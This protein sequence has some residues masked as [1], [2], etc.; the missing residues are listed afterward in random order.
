MIKSLRNFV[1]A[2]IAGGIIFLLPLAL[3]IMV[4]EK[5]YQMLRKILEPL[6]QMLPDKIFGLDGRMILTGLLLWTICFV[7][8]LLFLSPRVKKA[9]GWLEESVLSH[10]P[11]YNLTKSIAAD[12]IG[13]NVEDKM[14]PVLVQDG[15]A[16]KIGYL[17]E[18]G[19][20]Q[21]TVFYPDAP[22][23]DAGEVKIVPAAAVRKVDVPNNKVAQSLR[24]FGKGAIA[25]GGK[26]Q[27]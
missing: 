5:P 9:M 6:D 12:V 8:G 14:S 16:L 19:E 22:R 11:G 23:L 27:E 15:D 20:G 4:L 18:E 26:N 25:W 2:T 10:V 3:I 24:S 1:R 7:S 13:E 21:C 17:V